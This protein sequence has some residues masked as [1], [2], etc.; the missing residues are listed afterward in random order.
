MTKI[1]K[2][3]KSEKVHEY[4]LMPINELIANENNPNI[5]SAK[6]I[7]ELSKSITEWGFTNPILIDEENE[8]VAGHG[9]WEAAKLLNIEIV[10][11]IVLK[12]L[13]KT[14]RRAYVIADN[15]L[16]YGSVWDDELLKSEIEALDLEDFD[17]DLVGIDYL[18]L[19][20]FDPDALSDGHVS[21]PDGDVEKSGT[22]L[23]IGEYSVKIPREI[24][25]QWHDDIRGEVGFEKSDVIDEITKRLGLC[26]DS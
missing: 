6:N 10:P 23:Q 21:D 17:L 7:E 24:Y 8:I 13:T 12:G 16:P 1:V 4:I 22:K 3:E 26:L 20:D 18:S 2:N 5:H 25:L 11:C 19:D 9:R 14:Q 15:A